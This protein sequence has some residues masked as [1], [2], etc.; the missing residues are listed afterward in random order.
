MTTDRE[1]V[2]L[3]AEQVQKILGKKDITI[4][5]EKGYSSRTDINATQ[6][7]GMTENVPHTDTSGSA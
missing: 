5:A 1:Q 4:I 3:V 7:L 2:T 6:Y